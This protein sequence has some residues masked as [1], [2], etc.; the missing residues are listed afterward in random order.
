MDKREDLKNSLGNRFRETYGVEPGTAAVLFH[1]NSALR[2]M[3]NHLYLETMDELREC[4]LPDAGARIQGQAQL[5]WTLL[6]IPEEVEKLKND[7]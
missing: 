7:E 6:N 1:N 4:D 2:T 5:L 3:L